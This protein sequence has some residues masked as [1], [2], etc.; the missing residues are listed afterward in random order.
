MGPAC[1]SKHIPPSNTPA[2]ART[3]PTHNL[4]GGPRRTAPSMERHIAPSSMP[5]MPHT[6]TL[7]TPGPL[8]PRLA[9]LPPLLSRRRLARS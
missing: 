6:D 1:K 5:T 8:A 2:H 7:S 4:Y 3:K 9:K